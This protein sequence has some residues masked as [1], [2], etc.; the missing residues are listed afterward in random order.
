MQKLVRKLC[1]LHEQPYALLTGSG[2]AA[3]YSILKLLGPKPLKVGIP[4][5]VCFNVVLPIF[6]NGHI[7]I[8]LDI[9]AKTLGLSIDTIN[10]CNEKL[11]VI[12]AVHGY[13]STC[14]IL[15]IRDYCRRHHIF[16]IEDA[17]VAQG[18]T[19]NNQP[20]GSFGDVSII[21][22]GRG[23]II[24]V[25]HGGAILLNDKT[26]LGELEKLM[27]CFN[28]DT[29]TNARYRD[30]LNV[31]YTSFYNKYYRDYGLRVFEQNESFS[32]ML[33]SHS[34]YYFY[35][36]DESYADNIFMAMDSLNKNIESRNNNAKLL[37]GLFRGTGISY[38]QPANGSVYWRFNLFLEKRKRDKILQT[39]LKENFKI[40]SWFPSIDLFIEN[41][42]KTP[43]NT[44]ISDSISNS[45]LNIWLNNEIDKEYLYSISSR[46][47]EMYEFMDVE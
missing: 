13:G 27:E 42:D 17:C 2:T 36:F 8:Y 15:G 12:I 26:L 45:I 4:N 39:L 28:S 32:K 3:I 11:D 6:N 41:R 23:K 9:D 33:V 44:P 29:K 37:M 19:I 43:I 18:S 14:D 16:L 38:H 22:F 21:S 5:S 40:S 10:K 25:G 24:D 20:V 47:Q 46:I 30:I 31:K 34:K 35:K 7:P 1:E